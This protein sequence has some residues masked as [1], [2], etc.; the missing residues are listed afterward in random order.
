MVLPRSNEK[1]PYFHTKKFENGINIKLNF[2]LSSALMNLSIVSV[3]VICFY[4]TEIG[5]LSLLGLSGT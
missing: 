5:F 2:K 4:A 1:K 3:S